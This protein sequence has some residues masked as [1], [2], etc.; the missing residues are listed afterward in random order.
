MSRAQLP[1]PQAPIAGQWMPT[2]EWYQYLSEIAITADNVPELTAQ[3]DALDSRVSELEGASTRFV[4]VGSVSVSSSSSLVQVGLLNDLEAVPAWN[5]YGTDS[6]G[7]TRGFFE[8]PDN[9]QQA[10]EL[11]GTGFL[12]IDGGLWQQRIIVGANGITVNDN[13]TTVTLN[14]NP[15]FVASD[16]GDSPVGPASVLADSGVAAGAGAV[17]MHANSVALGASTV[18]DGVDQVA[19]GPRSIRI[20]GHTISATSGG[21]LYD[22]SPIGGGSGNSYMPGGW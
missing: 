15:Y 2:G 6:T 10:A 17:A 7:S 4:G 9:L 19:I 18:T 1:R 11:S 12:L 8:F 22:G 21:L 13:G 5:Y 14:G 3:I 16:N 20:N